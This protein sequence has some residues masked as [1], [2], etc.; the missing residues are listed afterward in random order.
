MPNPFK[1]KRLQRLPEPDPIPP[2]LTGM[3]WSDAAPNP[4]A[5][6]LDPAAAE[7]AER[8]AGA[9]AL[10]DLAQRDAERKRD[11]MDARLAGVPRGIDYS[12]GL[13]GLNP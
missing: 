3:G 2:H 11:D 4:G 9:V 7:A 13:R 10:A 5:L 12:K 1:S 8:R 6:P